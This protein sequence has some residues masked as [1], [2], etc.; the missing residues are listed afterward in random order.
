MRKIV[1]SVVADRDSPRYGR[2]AIHI[3]EN[4]LESEA[5][6]LD[7]PRKSK[8]IEPL[9]NELVSRSEE[10]KDPLVSRTITDLKTVQQEV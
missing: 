7:P 8:L 5:W 2:L 4:G 3:Q 1:I 6:Y 9:L 10:F